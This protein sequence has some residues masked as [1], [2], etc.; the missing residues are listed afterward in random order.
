MG[1]ALWEAIRSN[2]TETSPTIVPDSHRLTSIFRIL[3]KR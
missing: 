2:K 1:I 3:T